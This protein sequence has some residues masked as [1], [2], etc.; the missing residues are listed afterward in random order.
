MSP[1]VL[2]LS[3]FGL[4]C[5]EETQ[6]GLQLAGAQAEQRPLSQLFAGELALTDYRLLVLPGGFSYGDALGSGTVLAHKLRQSPSSRALASASLQDLHLGPWLTQMLDFVALGGQILGICNGFQV[7]CKLG[8]L[9]F[10]D[11]IQRASLAS[12]DSGRFENRWLHLVENPRGRHAALP[13]AG[14]WHW[15]VR[16][17]EG[18]LVFVDDQTRQQVQAQGLDVLHYS[19]ADGQ[20]TMT[21]PANPNG[22]ELACAGLTDPSGRILGMMPHPEAALSRYNHPDWPAHRA[23]GTLGDETGDGLRFFRQLLASIAA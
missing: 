3:G 21:Y 8:L 15:P 23:A 9:P 14:R 7:L 2:V 22:S 6:A 18:K 13:G 16:H 1:R 4:N 17:G 11:G 5:E 20:P 12:N 10:A 19:D